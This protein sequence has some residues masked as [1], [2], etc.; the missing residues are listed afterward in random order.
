MN[1]ISDYLK[2]QSNDEIEAFW[3]MALNKEIVLRFIPPME[4]EVEAYGVN[5]FQSDFA[6]ADQK[7]GTEFVTDGVL[8]YYVN[9][10]C[11]VLTLKNSEIICIKDLGEDEKWRIFLKSSYDLSLSQVYV[12]DLDYSKLPAT[13]TDDSFIKTISNAKYEV[14]TLPVLCMVLDKYLKSDGK[15]YLNTEAQNELKKSGRLDLDHGMLISGP[16]GLLS[17]LSK[18]SDLIGVE[19][20][21]NT[22]DTKLKHA[23][24]LLERGRA[25]KPK[26]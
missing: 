15:K 10:F 11:D 23:M 9:Q 16:K 4:M 12:N 25:P 13:A 19:I 2:K 1:F 17:V 8:S 3:R 7:V 6:L 5:K 24:E 22:I 18:D 21:R 20:A 26:R 14:S